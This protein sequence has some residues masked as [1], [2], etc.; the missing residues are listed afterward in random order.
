MLS[1]IV[2]AALAAVA[3]VIATLKIV[4]PKTKNTVD[5]RILARLEA[6]EKQFGVK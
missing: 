5:D 1:T 4:A 2:A 3:G 6:L